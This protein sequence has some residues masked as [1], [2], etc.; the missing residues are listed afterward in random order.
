MVPSPQGLCPRNR[1][2]GSKGAERGSCA[3]P[4]PRRPTS[5]CLSE[6]RVREE[7]KLCVQ[8]GRPHAY[9]R[10]QRLLNP[11]KGA[12]KVVVDWRAAVWRENLLEMQAG[13]FYHVNWRAAVWRENLLGDCLGEK[14][15][16]PQP[17]GRQI[18]GLICV[19]MFVPHP[20]IF[21]RRVLF[22][23][24]ILMPRRMVLGLVSQSLTRVRQLGYCPL[25]IA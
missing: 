2:R 11:G 21:N 13:P 25:W 19:V 3:L 14:V 20:V 5:L 6:V 7:R 8:P 17:H 22:P 16:L 23:F 4:H 12:Q 10:G 1:G 18:V 24:Q 9:L 15:A